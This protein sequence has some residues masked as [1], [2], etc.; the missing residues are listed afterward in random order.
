[1][2]AELRDQQAGR[3]EWRMLNALPAG[4]QADAIGDALPGSFREF[5]T[6]ADGAT[7]GDVTVFGSATVDQMQFHADPITGAAITLGREEWFCAGVISDEPFFINRST[8]AVWYFPDTGV[9]WWMSSAFEKAA[10][11]FTTFFLQWV[12]GREYVRLSA[13]GP[14]DQWA[15]LLRY[16]GRL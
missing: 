3:E 12:A 11:D 4:A 5:L 1:M 2:L 16:A 8:G 14:E 9:A 6:V 7:C 10:D 15:E 13:T